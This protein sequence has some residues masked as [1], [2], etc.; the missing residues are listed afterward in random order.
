MRAPRVEARGGVH[1][2]WRTPEPRR[3]RWSTRSPRKLTSADAVDRHRVPRHEVGQLATSARS[4]RDSGGEYKV[5]KNTLARFAAEKAGVDGLADLLVGPTCHDLRQ[6][7][8]RRRGQGAERTPPGPTRC[9][10][11]KG[12]AMGGKAMSAK[13]V[14]GLADLPGREV[15]LAMLAGALAGPAGEDRRPAA[16]AAA[17]LRLRPQG[18]HRPEGAA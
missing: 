5:Y 9:L 1:D 10:I 2:N 4:L 13:D 7:R 8:C 16:S 3:S 15:L 11:I 14:E 18:P 6:R 17:Q 12:G